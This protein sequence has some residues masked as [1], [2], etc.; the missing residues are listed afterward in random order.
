MNM[1]PTEES[2]LVIVPKKGPNKGKA[3]GVNVPTEVPEGRARPK[4][5]CLQE[6]AAWT[7]CQGIASFRLQAVRR[8]ARRNKTLRFTAL[9]HHITAELLQR[10]YYS[11][12]HG[13]KAGID[14]ITWEKYGENLKRNLLNLL[15]RIHNGSYRTKPALRVYIPKTDGS[16]RPLSIWSLEDKIVQ[17]AVVQVLN[18]IYETDFRDFSYGFRPNRSQHDALDALQV[19]IYKKK[20]NWI[21]DADIRKFFDSVDHDQLLKLL[22]LRIQDKRILRL[23]KKWL[24][25]GVSESGHTLRSEIGIPQ[26]AVVSPVLANVYLHY[27]YDLWVK[28]WRSKRATGDVIVIRYAD[29]SVPRAPRRFA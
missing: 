20:I 24:K 1:H 5:N 29:D 14:G 10:S 12:K 23:I 16:Q 4:G 18:A 13:A 21:L 27:V 25:V 26:G 3:T 9:L 19:A 7:Q 8:A 6:A 22:Q 2:D 11:L 15:Q 17:Q 28:A